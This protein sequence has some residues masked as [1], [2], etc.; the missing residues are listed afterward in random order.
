MQQPGKAEP[1]ARTA[2]R[3][4]VR[5]QRLTCV[6]F[7]EYDI[8]MTLTKLAPCKEPTGKMSG[9]APVLLHEMAEASSA[10]CC[11]SASRSSENT[12]C[13]HLHI[14]GIYS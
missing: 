10:T 13:L 4:H 8:V 5:V 3:Q 2:A 12:K 9:I 1:D 6:N 11:C 7:G 14:E